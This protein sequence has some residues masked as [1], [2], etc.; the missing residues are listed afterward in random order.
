MALRF[1]VVEGNTREARE[2]HRA[3]YGLTP[4]QS[5]AA[6]L[7]AIV[8]EA[9]S[10]IALPAD[11]GAN[12]PDAAGLETYDGIFLTGSALHAYHV[13]PAVTRQVELARAG[14][15]SRTPLFGSCW[16]IQMGAL[17][18]G[19]DVTANPVGREVGFARRI[20][21]HEA[22]RAHPLLAGR[23]AAFDAPA[24]HLDIVSGLPGEV[25]VLASNAL[26]PIQAAEIR[27][28]GGVMW[29][30][31]YHPEFSLA[32]L[33]V[34]LGRR[35]GLLIGEGFFAGEE[36]HARYVGELRA[37]HDDPARRDLAWKFGLDEEVLETDRRL[38]EI[39]NFV[40]HCVK[41]ARSRRG[42]A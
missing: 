6:V 10:D 42:R 3:A 32:E 28:E 35:G 9:V 29:G 24:I 39:R 8:P 20:V 7:Q 41:P 38:T 5:Y 26:T 4:S 2:G 13:E 36:D 37:L 12:L 25:T 23:P 14:F 31:Q 18:A 15:R 30:V 33:S 11:E 21:P 16:G 1:L 40:E 19:G 34:I 27:H 22:G 17:A